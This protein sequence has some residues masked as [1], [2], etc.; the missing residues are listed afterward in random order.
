M[1]RKI[2]KYQLII[3]DEQEIMIPRNSVFL[4]V[5]VQDGILCAWFAVNPDADLEPVKFAVVGTGNP[6]EYYK[7]TR[8]L[9]TVQMPP[10]VWHVFTQFS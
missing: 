2:Y 9:G 5:G 10:F 1:T 3:T 6:F 8:F 4:H 7:M